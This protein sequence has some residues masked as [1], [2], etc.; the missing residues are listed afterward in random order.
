MWQRASKK[1]K[2][3]EGFGDNI[4]SVIYSVFEDAYLLEFLSTLISNDVIPH[5]QHSHLEDHW[6]KSL[7]LVE[8][9][10]FQ[11]QHNYDSLI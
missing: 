2:C 9:R 1:Y 7:W 3:L 11:I 4:T 10:V 5:Q 6:N 8:Y